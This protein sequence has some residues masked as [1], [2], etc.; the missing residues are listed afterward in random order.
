MSTW[1]NNKIV[2]VAAVVIITIS[3]GMVIFNLVK[4][5]SKFK[6]APSGQ[7]VPAGPAFEQK[8]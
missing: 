4:E 2:G 7:V 1:S 5:A 3:L 6:K 8:K